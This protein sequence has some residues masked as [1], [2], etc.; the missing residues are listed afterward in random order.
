VRIGLDLDG[1]RDEQPAF[2][3][4]LTAALRAGGHFVAVLTYR[5]DAAADSEGDGC[6]RG[7]MFT[8]RDAERGA[9]RYHPAPARGT[10]GSV[11]PPSPSGPP[12]AAALPHRRR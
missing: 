10:S 3:A 2:F 8:L 12:T 11:A 4:F 5:L 6:P 9:S 1:L 7:T